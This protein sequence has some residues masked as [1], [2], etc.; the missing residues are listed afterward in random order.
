MVEWAGKTM[1]ERTILFRRR[2]PTKVISK[3]AL[4]R[5]Y[6]KNGARRKQ[7]KVDKEMPTRKSGHYEDQRVNIL[8]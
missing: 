2:F 8:K 7:I 3:S 4:Y 1:E 6:K 5:L